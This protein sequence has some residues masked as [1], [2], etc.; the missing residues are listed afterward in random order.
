M[1]KIDSWFIIPIVAAFIWLYGIQ[2]RSWPPSVLAAPIQQQPDVQPQGPDTPLI[3]GGQEAQIGAWPWMVALV[4]AGQADASQG[5]FCGGSLIDATWVLTAAHCTFRSS[6]AA[7][8]PTDID[9]VIGRHQLSANT[10]ERVDVVRIVRHPG[11][12]HG[13][14]FD[15]D[16]ALLE[17]ATAVAA[18]PIKFTDAQTVALE[19][20]ARSVTVIGW[21]VADN[22]QPSDVLRQVEIPL[23]DLTTCRLSYGIFDGEVTDNMLCAGLKAG[24]KDSCQGDSGGPLMT[25]DTGTSTWKQVGIVSWGDGC[26]APN[27][28]GVYTRLSRYA[29]W[30]ALQIPQLATPTPTLTHTPTHTPSA[31]PTTTGTRVATATPTAT[32]TLTPTPTRPPAEVFMPFVA[33]NIVVALANGNF[34]AG[35][36][37]W[38]QFSLQE[39]QLIVRAETASLTAHS[40][41]WIAWL[42]GLSQ[43]VSFIHQ[44]VTIPRQDPVLHFWY[45]I[46]SGDLCGYDFGGVVVDGVVVD[47]FDLCTT[48]QTGGWKLRTVNLTSYAGQTVTFQIRAE[49]D[50]VEPS[51]LL[52]D[53]VSI[54]AILLAAQLEATTP[55]SDP[56]PKLFDG[57]PDAR[58]LVEPPDVRLWTPAKR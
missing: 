14:N 12:R 34:E 57:S 7:R 39:E 26:A 55:Q 18:T 54:G 20:P 58:Q 15:N 3:I 27:F 43:E 35:S 31:T 33:Y 38:Q 1:K 8:P 52:I 40:G 22:E 47:K 48:T 53:D 51:T 17:L 16:V 23:V 29:D 46:S 13:N 4:A 36:S 56:A 25:F 9:I 19:T 2:A 5:Q 30:V 41:A 28:Y 6:G 32:P 11:Y 50:K 24:G 49:T 45:W 37:G 44:A 42:G 21:G 10:G